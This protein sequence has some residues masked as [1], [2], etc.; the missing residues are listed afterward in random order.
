MNRA[1][2]IFYIAGMTLPIFEERIE[3]SIHDAEKFGFLFKKINFTPTQHK[4]K[5]VLSK[6][7][8]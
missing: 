3:F 6:N 2:G 4:Q 1:M 8:T 7:M 5:T